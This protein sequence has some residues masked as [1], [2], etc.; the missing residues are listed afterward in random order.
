MFVCTKAAP[1]P[2]TNLITHHLCF[3]TAYKSCEVLHVLAGTPDSKNPDPY[4]SASSVKYTNQLIYFT[5]EIRNRQIGKSANSDKKICDRCA[6]D[7]F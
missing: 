5:C 1:P 7:S 3:L 4:Y 2:L 6:D